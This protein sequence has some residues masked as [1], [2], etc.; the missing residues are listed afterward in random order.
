MNFLLKLL[1]D[2]DIDT[3]GD[4]R[5]FLGDT[6]RAWLLFVILAV[7]AVFC[8][9]T[10]LRIRKRIRRRWRLAMIGTRISLLLVIFLLL[11]R[12]AIRYSR[13]KQPVVAILA[14][15]SASMAVSDPE[16]EEA[17][18]RHA[19]H[20]LSRA[21]KAEDT[22]E[23]HRVA[24]ARSASR[25]DIARA[26]IEAGP[27]AL[28]KAIS[29]EKKE[30]Y[31][32][33]LF[34]FGGGLREV[35]RL[36]AA[37]DA[38]TDM[39]A[40][41]DGLD[42]NLWGVPLIAVVL[43]SDG[44]YNAGREPREIAYRY[45]DRDVPIYAV[46]M[47]STRRRRDIRITGVAVPEFGF[48]KSLVNVD[49][50]LSSFGFDRVAIVQ[51]KE[52][53]RVLEEVDAELKAGGTSLRL[54]IPLRLTE[55]G[56]HFYSLEVPEA[57]G[58]MLTDNNRRRFSI[59]VLKSFRVLYITGTPRP[60]FSFLRRFLERDS[61]IR[62]TV[63]LRA[64]GRGGRFINASTEGI[65]RHLKQFPRTLEEL[66]PY[67]M[68]IFGDIEKDS[69][70][71]EQLELLEKYV[72]E[73][74]GGFL[75][76]GGAHSFGTGGYANS[77]V[78][79]LL[80][81]RISPEEKQV[82]DR[83]TLRLTAEGKGSPFFQFGAGLTKEEG[84]WKSLPPFGG[85]NGVS[86]PKP[87]TSVLA[88]HPTRGNSAGN[89]IVAATAR[90]GKG[91]TMALTVDE[92]WHWRFHK[93]Y[94]RQNVPGDLYRH[95]WGQVVR[96]LGIP[97]ERPGLR[98][99]LPRKHFA[100]GEEARVRAQLLGE[101]RE[102]L[103][104]FKVTLTITPPQ[105]DKKIV[106]TMTPDDSLRGGYAVVLEPAADGVYAL[107]AR[108][109]RETGGKTFTDTGEIWIEKPEAEI[110][111]VECNVP[112]LRDIAK[113]S[114][115][116]YFDLSESGRIV[117]HI[118]DLEYEEKRAFREVGEAEIWDAWSVL[119]LLLAIASLEWYFRKRAGIL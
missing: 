56:E 10:Y 99:I 75:M 53:D 70:A 37:T 52:G 100:T 55:P 79:D 101:D 86:G 109:E 106:K 31:E 57:E 104:G 39:A 63:L 30:G 11:L 14:D 84:F 20:L 115:G 65:D 40:G 3:T 22:S 116:R 83:F 105:G 117:R 87:G 21:E 29:G 32:T 50:T 59:E 58:E 61:R 47:G 23:A 43:A 9:W 89:W 8:A 102:P 108:A 110:L 85:L 64:P 48:V 41:L 113:I 1:I 6:S 71:P 60:E 7:A 13:I 82:D 93:A 49:F 68:V 80:P 18:L 35:E 95:F 118:A 19:G 96:W 28:R 67:N 5:F 42:R 92:T 78:A 4:L 25:L 90:Y 38:R 16:A 103:D 24:Q 62:V 33:R 26:L 12:P 46:G 74:G 45:A 34:A 76:L 111:K 27:D 69:F 112:L 73:H 119:V 94:E 15:T 72:G 44:I 98:I 97:S 114:K 91:R 107:E 2:R 88:V 54:G 51:L 36:P 66:K 17:Y 81:V 77:R